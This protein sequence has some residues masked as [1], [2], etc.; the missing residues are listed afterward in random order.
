MNPKNLRA[1]K[2]V[3]YRM[4]LNP[5]GLAFRVFSYQHTTLFLGTMPHHPCEIVFVSCCRLTAANLAQPISVYVVPASTPHVFVTWTRIEDPIP[6][7]SPSSFRIEDRHVQHKHRIVITT[8]R[9]KAGQ[10]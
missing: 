5:A 10:S 4:R 3:L 2:F 1:P 7:S 8:A 9:P 6:P